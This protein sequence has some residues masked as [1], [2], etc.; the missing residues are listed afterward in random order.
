[1]KAI[2][3]CAIVMSCVL[4][5]FGAAQDKKTPTPPH[6]L[7]GDGIAD[8][9]GKVGYFPN[10]TGGIDALDLTSGR[11][12][13]SAIDAKKPLLATDKRLFAQASVKG[14]ANQVRVAVYDVTLEGKLIFESEPIVFPD[15]VSVPVT[16][17][18][19]FRSSARLDVKGLWLSWEANAFYAG[20]AAPTEEILKAARK[21]ASGVARID[22]DSRKVSAEKGGPVFTGTYNPK[23]GA[24]TLVTVDGPAKLK[25]NPFARRRLL[26][27]V[28]AGKQVVW[29]REIAAPVFLIP[30]P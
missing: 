15:W 30:R 9:T 27:A 18:R 21:N 6:L 28:N 8:P 24:L 16:Y 17:G 3:M 12:L 10:T 2:L 20:G 7:P 5:A 26:R 23:V 1:M 29:E 11:L 19:S 13:W 14:K 4:P 22:L 25:G